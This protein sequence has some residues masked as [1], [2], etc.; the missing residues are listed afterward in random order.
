MARSSI[1][2]NRPAEATPIAKR[3]EDLWI[4]GATREALTKALFS[5]VTKLPESRRAPKE[6]IPA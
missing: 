5:G 2:Q 6:A 3:R 1:G 4:Q